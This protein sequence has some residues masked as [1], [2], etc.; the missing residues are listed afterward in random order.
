MFTSPKIS[1]YAN[2][3]KQDKCGAVT[4][5]MAWQGLLEEKNQPG[6]SGKEGLYWEWVLNSPERR[7]AGRTWVHD[8]NWGWIER[9]INSKLPAMRKSGRGIIIIIKDNTISY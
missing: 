3:E 6:S 7:W 5:G 2:K 4:L 8:E 9:D 1:W